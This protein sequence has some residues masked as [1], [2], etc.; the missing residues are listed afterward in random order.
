MGSSEVDDLLSALNYSCS[1][2]R[3]FGPE[4]WRTMLPDAAFDRV[5]SEAIQCQ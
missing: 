4:D 2:V 5:D 1:S 3:W